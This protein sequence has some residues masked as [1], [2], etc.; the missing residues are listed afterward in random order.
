MRPLLWLEDFNDRP[1]DP[2]PVEQQAE[3]AIDPDPEPE[4]LPDPCAEA[5]SDGFLAGSRLNQQNAR[6]PVH[7]FA[8]DL[9]RRLAEI[10]ERLEA[11][12]DNAALA[13][14]GLLVDMLAAA[15]P[16]NWPA[17][18]ADRLHGIAEAIRPV[19]ALDP[20]LQVHTDPPG[21]IAYRDLPGF[22]KVLE[23]SQASDWPLG[24]RWDTQDTPKHV[25][26]KLKAAIDGSG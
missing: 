2:P 3:D 4:I 16:D 14:G 11:V 19:F 10:E 6:E 5:W 9:G 12:A 21:E 7:G 26:D 1:S 8:A 17:E 15:L 20:M 25:A 24:T 18:V 22:Y 23:A 13:M